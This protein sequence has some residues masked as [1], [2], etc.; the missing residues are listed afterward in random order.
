[1][2]LLSSQETEPVKART[3]MNTNMHI[4]NCSTA[5]VCSGGSRKGTPKKDKEVLGRDEKQEWNVWHEGRRK[6]CVVK[7]GAS[8]TKGRTV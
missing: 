3:H 1:M 8:Q 7:E 5:C 2:L 4:H 6:D